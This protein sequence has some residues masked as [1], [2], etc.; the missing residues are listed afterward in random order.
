MK[1]KLADKEVTI[2]GE[3]SSLEA[4]DSVTASV[5]L[6]G[7]TKQTKI[8][9]PLTASGVSIDPDEVQ[10]TLTPVKKSDSK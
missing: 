10:V 4:I 5:S 8:K 9:V 3:Q 6:T 2:Y 7:I 1:T